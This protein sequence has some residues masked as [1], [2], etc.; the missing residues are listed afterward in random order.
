MRATR[1]TQGGRPPRWAAAALVLGL[2][3]LSVGVRAHGEARL[4]NGARS[5]A[6]LAARV[7]AAAEAGD[8]PAL[9]RLALSREEFQRFVWPEL[10]VSNPKTNVSLDYVWKDVAVRSAAYRERLLASLRGKQLS[11]VRLHPRKATAEYPSHRALPDFEVTLRDD[12]GR[13][14]VYPLFGTLIEM[15]GVLKVYS[16]APYH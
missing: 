7:L 12:S 15:D 1:F 13:E 8:R 10:P 14:G 4:Q 5:A 11:V 6:D 3:V 16:Y 2:G 9:E